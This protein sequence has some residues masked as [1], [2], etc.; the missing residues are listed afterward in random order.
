MGS[1]AAVSH[2]LS[3]RDVVTAVPYPLQVAAA[4][5][6][7]LLAVTGMAVLVGYVLLTLWEVVVPVGVALLLTALL[8]PVVNWL[9]RH[10]VPSGLAT[11]VVLVAGLALIGGLLTFV[12]TAFVTGLPDLSTQV[13]NSLQQIL[14][15][16][17]RSSFGI[18]PINTQNV[19]D[20]LSRLVSNNRNLITTGA[21][22]AALTVG[23]YLSGAALTLF[24]LIYF[25]H[26][27]DSIWRFLLG[28]VPRPVRDRIDVAGQRSYAALVGFIRASVLVAVVDAVGT[29]IGLI[30]VGAPLVLPLAALTFLAAFIPVIGTVVSGMVAVLVVLVAKD[31]VSA[32]IVLGVVIGVQQLESNILQPLLMGRAVKLN[33]LAVVLTVAVGTAIAGIAGALLAV[34]LLSMLNTGIRTLISMDAM[35]HD[36]TSRRA[37]TDNV[38]SGVQGNGMLGH[39]AFPPAD[40]LADL[41]GGSRNGTS[42]NRT[43][44]RPAHRR[45]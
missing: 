7:R 32:L 22:S 21:L 13:G 4:V 20:S 17:Q 26:S 33:G 29:G 8:G 38:S 6:W 44:S 28:A 31:P 42:P 37:P 24:V 18:P 27:G 9:A 41:A 36:L 43:R 45:R 10:R 15:W 2:S 30:A 39:S 14:V 35:P 1:H 19:L 11:L 23:H 3:P 16:L 5:S 40:F 34:P 25:L 12:I